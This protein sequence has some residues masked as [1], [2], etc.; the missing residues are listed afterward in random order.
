VAAYPFGEEGSWVMRR[1]P[2]QAG[3]GPAASLPFFVLF[4]F[5]VLWFISY[6]LQ[7]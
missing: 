1:F 6:L 4:A 5:S 2:A 3:F 7:I